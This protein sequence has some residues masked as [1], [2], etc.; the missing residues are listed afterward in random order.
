MGTRYQCGEFHVDAANRCFLRRDREIAL[1]PRVFAVIAKLLA[2]AGSLV[3]RNELLDAV[4]G[5]RYVT[6][7]TL[8]R[9]IG[10]A[11]RAFGDDSE[12][13]RYI[14]TVHGAGYRYIGPIGSAANETVAVKARFGPPPTA[15]LPARVDELIGRERELNELKELLGLHR[16][17]TVTGPG[18]MGK[19]QCALEAA[20][21]AMA[22]FPDGVW[23]FDLARIELAED[24]LRALGAALQLPSAAPDLLLE[25]ICDGLSERGAL[26]VLDNCDRLAESLGALRTALTGAGSRSSARALSISGERCG[27]T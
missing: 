11:R 23:F 19:T 4:W 24:W 17:L 9:T 21:R 7:S 1:E 3:S 13:P 22:D 10:L 5:H 20:R 27:R 12:Q 2:R 6:P 26:L 25:H 15:R 18:G 8:N 14:Q 16:A